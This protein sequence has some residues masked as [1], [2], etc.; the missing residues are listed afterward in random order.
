MEY[1]I[2]PEKHA[3]N[4]TKSADMRVLHSIALEKAPIIPD[5]LNRIWQQTLT[6]LHLKG[7]DCI[8]DCFYRRKQAR[9]ASAN[10][11]LCRL[12]TYGFSAISLLYRLWM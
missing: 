12:V 6:K 10:E 8:E 11:Q 1:S 4:I 5:S 7:K 3:R 9:S 2:T